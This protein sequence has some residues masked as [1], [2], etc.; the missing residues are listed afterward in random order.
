MKDASDGFQKIMKTCTE[1]NSKV[2]M[3]LKGIL[4]QEL[5]NSKRASNLNMLKQTASFMQLSCL[6]LLKEKLWISIGGRDI[7]IFKSLD[8]C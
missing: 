3:K 4:C 6:N 5:H 8:I 7:K 1:N 2:C